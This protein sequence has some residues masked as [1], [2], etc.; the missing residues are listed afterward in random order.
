[1]AEPRYRILIVDD[2]TEDRKAYRRALAR[3]TEREFDFLEAETGE[4]GLTLCRSTLPDCVI[5]D[6][7]LPDMDAV[8][9]LASLC[10]GRTEPPV[11]V[12]VLTGQGNEAVAVRALKAGAQDYLVKGASEGEIQRAVGAAIERHVRPMDRTY[13]VLIIEDSPE[14]R[15]ICRRHLLQG[16]EQFEFMEAEVGE[17]GIALCRTF[18]PDC[19][20]LD[21]GLPDMD[22]IEVLT[23][24]NI[25][26]GR[27]SLAIIMLTGQGNEALAVRALKAGAEDYFVKGPALDGLGQA[28]R[29]A[30]E[31]AALRRRLE[32]ERREVERSRNELQVTLTSIGDAVISTDVRGGITFLN[33]VAESLTGWTSSEA[34]GRSLE[35]VFVIVNEDS[36]MAAE[37]PALRALREG[38]VVGLANHTLLIARDGVERPIDD[39][40]APIRDEK[41]SVLGAVLVFRDVTERRR[42]EQSLLLQSRVLESMIEGV[43][44]ADE[45]GVIFYTNPTEDRLFGYERG[46][47][48]GRHV[49]VQN[50]YSPEEN[51]RRVSEVIQSLRDGGSWTG[52]WRNRRKDGSVFISFARITTLDVRGRQCLVCVRED[53][54]DR[55]DLEEELQ[56]RISELAFAARRKDEFL[57]MLAHELRNPLAPIRNS[58]HVL[59]LK[60]GDWEAI[61][62]VR[63]I[64]ERQVGHLGRL[65]DDL[66]DVSRITQGKVELKLERVDLA[67]L[68]RQ[69]AADHYTMFESAEITLNVESPET[70]V[71]VSGDATRLT[72]V[73]DNLLTNALKF[74]N[75]GGAVR[76]SV[77]IEGELAN[78]SV[79]DNGIGIPAELLSGVFDVF[80]QADK[81]LARS[82]GGLGLGLAIVSRLVTMHGGTVSARS[83]GHGRGS[84]IVFD[85]PLE[86]EPPPLTPAEARPRQAAL[87]RRILVVEDNDDSAETLRMLLKLSG[88]E[89]RV[90]HTGTE[91]VRAAAEWLPDT[92]I[93]D[94]G[95]PELDGFAV[96]RCLRQEPST[97][98]IRLIALTG[99]GQPEDTMNAR[100]AGFDDLLVKPADPDQLFQTLQ[101]A[102]AAT[103]EPG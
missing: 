84:E 49:S 98:G 50:D 83:E 14:D 36:R 99:Y 53:I 11:P 70:P 54:T 87:R 3:L 41:G 65:V 56:R 68:V 77:A 80:A 74:T 1:M 18:N 23:R 19:V 6:H 44:V 55:K 32:E 12:V 94:I 58:L 48:S 64:M 75:P 103:D 33:G 30:V 73:L 4:E 62:V 7:R 10:H 63:E 38:V 78:V 59:K 47:L 17:A 13:R 91:G 100:E 102:G 71:W 57:A 76:I 72:Q 15:E 85:L 35:E 40:A 61:D 66:L 31:K 69:C 101:S 26:Y 89:V 60:N 46:E 20:L 22:G 42:T 24:L 88:Y 21:Y 96:A 93:C 81:S 86:Q 5:L 9:F 8:S 51:E 16:P 37:N 34:A 43:S 90:A 82:R 2:S 29:S 45:N 97:A 28:V 25:E 27:D 79:R 67:R 52:E 95:L 39:S 92:V